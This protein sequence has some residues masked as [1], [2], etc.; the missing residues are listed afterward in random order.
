MFDNILEVASTRMDLDLDRW[1]CMVL[2]LTPEEA[3]LL[4]WIKFSVLQLQS[5]SQEKTGFQHQSTGY[6]TSTTTC[7]CIIILL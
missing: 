5:T 3:S 2:E 1:I 6:L 4:Q 7:M